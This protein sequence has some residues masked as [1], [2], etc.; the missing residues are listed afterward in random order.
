MAVCLD[1]PPTE[2]K[3]SE[4]SASALI[5]HETV[6]HWMHV[7]SHQVVT[8]LHQVRHF[9]EKDHDNQEPCLFRLTNATKKQ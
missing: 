9:T 3:G 6:T 5:T 1:F 4:A 2:P 7:G 8:R